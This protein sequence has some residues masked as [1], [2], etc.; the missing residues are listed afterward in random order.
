MHK[1]I[2]IAFILLITMLSSD[3]M[4]AV[5]TDNDGAAFITKAEYDSLKNDFQVRLDEF[6]SQIDNKLND[7]IATYLSGIKSG[8]KG[9]NK[10]CQITDYN[11]IQWRDKLILH[12]V[13]IR[14]FTNAD[15]YTDTANQTW[16]WTY[17]TIMQAQAA[18]RSDDM[19]TKVRNIPTIWSI[20]DPQGYGGWELILKGDLSTRANDGKL[21]WVNV[22]SDRIIQQAS[23]PA[24]YYKYDEYN[25]D[26]KINSNRLKGYYEWGES[27]TGISTHEVDHTA[28]TDSDTTTYQ[29]S[30]GWRTRNNLN[31]LRV[32]KVGTPGK[33]T[34]A[35]GIKIYQANGTTYMGGVRPKKSAT[36]YF[37]QWQNY[38][39]ANITHCSYVTTFPQS[40]PL[41]GASQ[42]ESYDYV[43]K[44][45][46]G[47]ENTQ[48]VNYLTENTKQSFWM[49]NWVWP[50]DCYREYTMTDIY[51]RKMPIDQGPG[52]WKDGRTPDTQ[53]R[54][55]VDYLFRAGYEN[56]LKFNSVPSSLTFSLPTKP[57]K[58]LKLLDT[59]F[60]S[61]D[62]NTRLRFGDGLPVIND[63][64][65]NCTITME[66]DVTSNSGYNTATYTPY[67]ELSDADFN[68]R[69]RK[70]IA[71]KDGTKITG[72]PN[73]YK[74][75]KGHNTI[76][77]ELTSD[78]KFAWA[79]FSP[80]DNS[81]KNYLSIS[82][83][84]AR[85][86]SK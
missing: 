4:A 85:Y 69:T 57:H 76:K 7:A 64:Y 5:V 23:C 28:G 70:S 77:F 67:I 33:D 11:T 29:S 35:F 26:D 53:T 56:L 8:G 46:C 17:D 18:I 40:Y 39:N 30:N 79:R 81:G 15:T 78:Q 32:I 59:N 84:K 36:E 72:K 48:E 50:E 66:F 43:C 49:S 25:K 44:M 80:G 2:I 20:F 55:A 14:K 71:V 37:P 31:G 51:A 82:N 34:N 1:K 83:I 63:N 54:D 45:M 68:T 58:K 12:D 86:E 13:T 75:V 65:Y 16:E 27:F 61:K 73:C 24:L 47:N 9:D 74:I 52:N 3:L 21:Y 41:A 22:P 42:D 60:F 10:E 38:R 6:N 62:Q 19:G